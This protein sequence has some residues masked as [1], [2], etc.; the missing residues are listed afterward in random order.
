MR[1]LT[2]WSQLALATDDRSLTETLCQGATDH[3][4]RVAIAAGL[5]FETAVQLV[6]LNPARHMRLTPWVGAV[7]P[8]RDADLVLLR[9]DPAAVDWPGRATDTV[10]RRARHG[11]RH[12]GRGPGAFG[13]A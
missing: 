9:G 11:A 4:L 10:H 7:A 12:A 6:T 3:N 8:G 13:R 1:G 2:D 5:P